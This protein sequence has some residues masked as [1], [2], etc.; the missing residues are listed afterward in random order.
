MHSTIA[1]PELSMQLSSVYVS[2]VSIAAGDE[3]L[4]NLQL[5]HCDRWGPFKR[6]S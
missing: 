2:L 3:D 6:V 1:A 4:M 5:N